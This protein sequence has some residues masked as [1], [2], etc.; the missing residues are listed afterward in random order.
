MR[1]GDVPAGIMRA[2]PNRRAETDELRGLYQLNSPER[3]NIEW[4]RVIDWKEVASSLWNG[5]KIGGF[6]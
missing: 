6:C 5:A 3:R 1:V 2:F 4:E